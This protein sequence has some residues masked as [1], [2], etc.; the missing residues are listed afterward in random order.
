MQAKIQFLP[1]SKKWLTSL[2][3]DGKSATTIQCYACDLRHVSI[4]MNTN[5][6]SD[7]AAADQAIVDRLANVWSTNGASAATIER[8][9]STMRGFA[10]FLLRNKHVDSATALS[11]HYPKITGIHALLLSREEISLIMALVSPTPNW[12]DLR[13]V[14][15]LRLQFHNGLTLTEAVSLNVADIEGNH[16]RIR[17]SRF[18]SRTIELDLDTDHL[19]RRYLR[20]LAFRPSPDNPLFLSAQGKRLSR[21][22]LQLIVWR[23]R[24]ECGLRCDGRFRLRRSLCL[25]MAAQG[26]LPNAI[27]GMLGISTSR[28]YRLIS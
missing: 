10:R 8:R 23:R 2:R 11:L 17:A 24:L 27:A 16:L 6:S 21:R 1:E 22:S 25:Q 15:A 28:A 13:N 4:A 18:R 9:F 14:C 19:I 12:R 20:C 5:R 7:L 3:T 26:H